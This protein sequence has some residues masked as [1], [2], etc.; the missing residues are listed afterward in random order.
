VFRIDTIDGDTEYWATSDL[1][2]T[3]TERETVANQVWTIEV[4]HRGLKQH[5]GIERCAARKARA[6]RNHIGWAIRAFLR[7]E[8]NRITTGTRWFE[9]KLAIIRPAIQQFLAGPKAL[10]RGFEQATLAHKRATA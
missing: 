2:M 8:Y 10:L 5:C 3:M 1:T 6:Q 4:Y 9:T 7:L